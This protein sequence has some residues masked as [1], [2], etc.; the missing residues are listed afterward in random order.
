[1][2]GKLFNFVLI[3]A[4]FF[5][6]FSSYNVNAQLFYPQSPDENPELIE[7]E[8]TRENV[9]ATGKEI[10]VDKP[11]AGD[12]VLAGQKIL[13]RNNVGRSIF[14]LALNVNIQSERVAGAT[15]IVG[16]NVSI[17]GNFGEELIITGN[18][19]TIKNSI[20]MGDLIVTSNRLVLEN[21]QIIGS[22]KLSYVNL[23]GDL[24][25]QVRGKITANQAPSSET[26]K[27]GNILF[28]IGILAF[29]GLKISSIVFLLIVGYLLHRNNALHLKGVKFDTKFL[30]NILVGLVLV[31]IPIPFLV[32][33]FILQLYPLIM[34][35][36]LIL[37]LLF[38]LSSFYLPIYVANLIKNTFNLKIKIHY[39]V[40]FSFIL[41]L[42]LQIIPIVNLI[43]FVLFFIIQLANFTFLSKKLFFTIWNSFKKANDDK[44]EKLLV[45]EAVV[46]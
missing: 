11:V 1:M 16:E 20:I 35:L 44:Q 37:Y 42:V 30:I 23:D 6:I 27:V 3:L 45:K 19:V 38:I 10:R 34:L 24:Q 7:V 2:F 17:E 36:T 32:L 22:A 28:G 12:L 18:R 15:R 13:I 46:E 4:S 29:L 5:V 43:A 31:L 39:L 8:S 9:Y 41:M 14:A 40:I 26:R 33:S 21:S 25:E